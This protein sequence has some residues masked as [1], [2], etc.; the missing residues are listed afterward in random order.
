LHEESITRAD[1]DH[2][3]LTAT[4][5]LANDTNLSTT[6]EAKTK[7]QGKAKQIVQKQTF[8]LPANPNGNL[9]RIVFKVDLKAYDIKSDSST[10]F[11]LEGNTLKRGATVGSSSGFSPDSPRAQ[12]NNTI[13]DISDYHGTAKIEEKASSD[14]VNVIFNESG[15]TGAKMRLAPRSV[16]RLILRQ[17]K[18]TPSQSAIVIR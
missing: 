15:T 17:K 3:E 4:E 1:K 8:S 10:S 2:L 7:G 12:Y 6:L 14:E 16:L 9:Q 11:S 5:R 13:I 18:M